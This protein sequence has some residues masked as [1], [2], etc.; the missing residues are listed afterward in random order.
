MWRRIGWGEG[1]GR[2]RRRDSPASRVP[3]DVGARPCSGGHGATTME[4]GKRILIV[5]DE[6][7]LADLVAYNLQ[8]S[9]FNARV[10]HNGRDG[11]RTMETWRPDIVVL[12]VMMPEVDGLEVARRMRDDPDLAT[13]P[14][15]MLT[16]LSDEDDEIRGLD[17][18]A[19]DY[20]TK[21]FSIKILIKRIEAL[22]RRAQTRPSRQG[23]LELGPLCVDMDA[24]AALLG[25]QPMKL[26]VTEFRLLAA[27]IAAEGRVLSRASMITEAMGAGVTVTERTV[28][29]H[30]TSIRKKLGDHAAMV[31]TVRGVGY[32]MTVPDPHAGVDGDA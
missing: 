22:L 9:G 29:V 32:R 21:P 27:L 30:I 7:D 8:R 19:D 10:V 15:V 28:D 3:Y 13:V 16:A 2:L 5:D 20:L 31:Q 23:Q 17:A 25:G 12:D 4:E 1:E 11:L 6:A 18:G 24:H 26:T 14:V